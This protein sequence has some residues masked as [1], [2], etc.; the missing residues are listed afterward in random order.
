[1]GEGFFFL[2]I[3]W[4][5][6]IQINKR[7]IFP[8]FNNALDGNVLLLLFYFETLF[9]YAYRSTVNSIKPRTAT[10]LGYDNQHIFE[11]KIFFLFALQNSI[12]E[13]ICPL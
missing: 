1:M 8:P 6:F 5:I 7:C 2:N 11:T 4:K 10:I 13:V 3:A 12:Q 9:F